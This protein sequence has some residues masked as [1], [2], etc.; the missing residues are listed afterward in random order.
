[1]INQSTITYSKKTTNQKPERLKNIR[2]QNYI[3]KI[4]RSFQ[5][6]G[7]NEFQSAK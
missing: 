2:S 6:R 3:L 1:L 7:N 4:Q 5:I